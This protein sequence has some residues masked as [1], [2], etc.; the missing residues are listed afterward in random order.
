MFWFL[1]KKQRFRY[2]HDIHSHLLPGIDDGVKGMEE[3]IAAI[4]KLHALGITRF[5]VTPHIAPPWMPNSAESILPLLG[6]LRARLDAEGIGVE[7]EAAAEYRVTESM[8]SLLERPLLA[9][10]DRTL[11]IEHSYVT[12]SPS[13]G[14]VLDRVQQLGYFPVLAHPERY[15]FMQ[16]RVEA[17]CRRLRDRDCRVQLNLLSF[18]GKYG[19]APEKAAWRLIKSGQVDFVASDAHCEADADL[20]RDFLYSRSAEKLDR[21]FRRW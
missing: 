15:P 18:A 6:E 7:M 12:P 13:F 2:G 20:L 16:D 5:T 8:L 19:S 10:S 14:K 4:R 17:E 3:S 21:F 11:L 1:S 9:A